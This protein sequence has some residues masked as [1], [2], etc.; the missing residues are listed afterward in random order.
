MGMF[1]EVVIKCPG[2]GHQCLEQTKAGECTLA[3][4]DIYDR[5][6]PTEILADVAGAHVCRECGTHYT[7]HVQTMV[8]VT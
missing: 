4:W 1:D 3:R 7:I 8:N 6:C 5:E 2:C